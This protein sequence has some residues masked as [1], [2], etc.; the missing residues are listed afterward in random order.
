MNG[1]LL[2]AKLNAYA[3][4][5][6]DVADPIAEKKAPK[7]GT[8]IVTANGVYSY[9][10]PTAESISIADIAQGLAHECRYLGHVDSHYSVAQHC[11]HIAEALYYTNRPMELCLLGLLHDAPEAY[12]GDMPSPLKKTMPPAVRNWFEELERPCREIICAKWLPSYSEK[13]L[14]KH[15]E[16]H[17]LDVAIRVEEAKYY[18]ANR[19]FKWPLASGH[20][21][22]PENCLPRKPWSAKKAKREYLKWFSILR[23]GMA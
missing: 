11:V 14:L 1:H 2:R 17:A 6:R 18:L 21:I 10:S 12:F 8:S 4:I 15:E 13:D 5:H 23:E 3:E 9:T 20:V 19:H 7:E 22:F 16:I